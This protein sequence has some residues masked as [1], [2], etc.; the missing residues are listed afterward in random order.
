[1]FVLL[2]YEKM[3]ECENMVICGTITI[4]EALCTP[5]ILET[6]CTPNIFVTLCTPNILEALCTLYYIRNLVY[7]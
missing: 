6:L 3:C 1:M 2:I 5:I 4:L 7:S